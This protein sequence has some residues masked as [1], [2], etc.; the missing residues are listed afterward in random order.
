MV[1]KQIVLSVAILSAMTA[2]EVKGQQLKDLDLNAP[3]GIVVSR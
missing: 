2:V 1:L 3:F